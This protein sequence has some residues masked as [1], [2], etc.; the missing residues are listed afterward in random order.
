VGEN[1]KAH[2]AAGLGEPESKA[3]V[4]LQKLLGDAAC[5]TQKVTRSVLAKQLRKVWNAASSS[6]HEVITLVNKLLLVRA[7]LTMTYE[8]AGHVDEEIRYNNKSINSLCG[9]LLKAAKVQAEIDVDRLPDEVKVLDKSPDTGLS[10]FA[11]VHT[12]AKSNQPL[13]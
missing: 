7:V 2:K 11:Q 1:K 5:S 9:Q 12:A 8:G 4:A 13:N 10:L 6:P 3:F